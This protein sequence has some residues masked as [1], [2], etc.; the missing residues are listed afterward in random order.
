MS[1]HSPEP[2]VPRPENVIPAAT[3]KNAM[4]MKVLVTPRPILGSRRRRPLRSN[5]SSM[6]FGKFPGQSLRHKTQIRAAGSAILRAVDILESSIWDNTY[7][8]LI[9]LN[10]GWRSCWKD[11]VIRSGFQ[12]PEKTHKDFFY[13]WSYL[14]NGRDQSWDQAVA[15]FVSVTLAG[16]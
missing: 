8:P 10:R 13:C 7:A 16:G 9:Y 5:L 4:P 11:R 3:I 2:P 15:L 6:S 1:S 12:H 14:D